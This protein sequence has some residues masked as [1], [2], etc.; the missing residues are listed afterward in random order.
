[1]AFP[2][3]SVIDDFTRVDAATLGANWGGDPWSAGNNLR[4]VSNTARSQAGVQSNNAYTA[5]TYGANCEAF[6]SVGGVTANGYG[7]VAARMTA[8]DGTSDGYL[9][10]AYTVLGVRLF[11]YTDG[12]SFVQL[13]S[14]FTQTISAGDKFGISCIGTSIQAW[15]KAGAGAWTS[16]ISV[17]DSTYAAGGNIG[18]LVSDNNFYIDDFGGGTSTTTAATGAGSL[19]LLGVG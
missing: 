13:G 1:M 8:T 3:T 11:K 14:T 6:A 2:T 19:L 12:G 4:I 18:A 16:V 15:Y 17:T 5:A 10:Q 7:H 9:V